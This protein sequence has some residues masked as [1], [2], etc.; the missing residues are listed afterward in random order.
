MNDFSIRN[1]ARETGLILSFKQWRDKHSVKLANVSA[2]EQ[3]R[4]Y[5]Q[6]R[7]SRSIDQ[8]GDMRA[9][10][11]TSPKIGTAQNNLSRGSLSQC[12]R[13]YAT[14]LIDPW[15]CKRAP[16]VPDTIVLPSYKFGSRMKGIFTV[17]S[18]G[19]GYVAVNAY[20]V[21][22]TPAGEVQQFSGLATNG[23]FAGDAYESSALGTDAQYNDGFLTTARIGFQTGKVQWRLVG[24][25]VKARYMGTEIARSGRVTAYRST[26]NSNIAACSN[27][28]TLL[29]SRE[30]TASPADRKYHYVTYRPAVP[31]DVAYS[32]QII[33][34]MN[35][36]II[37][38]GGQPGQSFE[39]D[40]QWWFETIGG[41][42][43]SLTM[44]H[45]D[46]VGMAA[47][48][49]ALP[50]TQPTNSPEAELS[51]FWNKVVSVAK[52]AFSFIAPVIGGFVNNVGGLENVIPALGGMLL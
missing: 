30:A 9:D 26:F 38:D 34:A 40:A 4:R 22:P 7:I 41:Q 47:V 20:A 18:N 3:R 14:A 11:Y 33:N 25:G 1:F 42:L 21:S 28:Q 48:V 37:V 52:E 2:T 16:C 24:C 27:S 10:Y 46:P 8:S 45:S 51:S 32:D 13:D 6:Y 44:S 31:D 17:G 49:G 43:P 35:L 50:T 39:Y 29:Q 5:D 19:V 36:L 15:S 12:S 23:A